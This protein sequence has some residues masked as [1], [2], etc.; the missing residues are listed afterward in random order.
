M[1][2]EAVLT[3]VRSWP[4]EERLR[5]VRE[6]WDDLAEETEPPEL[7]EDLK[8]LLDHRIDALEKNPEAVVPW[9]AVEARALER[10]RKR[11]SLSS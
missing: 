11:T 2:F 3:A 8:D 6:L 4:T 5:L 7:I 9:E 1:D 10:F